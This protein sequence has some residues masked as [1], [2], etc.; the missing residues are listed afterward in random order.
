MDA[1]KSKSKQK[2]PSGKSSSKTM[3]DKRKVGGSS[4]TDRKNNKR[5]ATVDAQ[6]SKRESSTSGRAKSAIKTKDDKKKRSK[7]TSQSVRFNVAVKVRLF[8]SIPVMICCLYV[9]FSDFYF[10]T[11]F[12]TAK[13]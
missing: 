1:S 10:I 6:L 4:T 2:Q 11:S 8:S 12:S 9:S 3:Q 5:K 13:A 7:T